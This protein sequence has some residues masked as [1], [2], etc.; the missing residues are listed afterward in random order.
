VCESAT[1]V[2]PRK[3]PSTVGDQFAGTTLGARGGFHGSEE[4]AVSLQ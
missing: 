1:T 2:M 4:S 3:V